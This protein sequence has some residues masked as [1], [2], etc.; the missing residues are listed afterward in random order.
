MPFFCII[1]KKT[2][3][4]TSCLVFLSE[5]STIKESIFFFGAYALFHKTNIL[6]L[7]IG[8]HNSII[9]HY[10]ETV[11]SSKALPHLI[12]VMV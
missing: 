8:C 12:K 7:F 1:Q 11:I 9:Q 2:Y 6:F 5:R 10:S 4:A 3:C